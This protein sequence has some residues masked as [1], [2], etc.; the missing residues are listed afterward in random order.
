MGSLWF[1]GLLLGVCFYISLSETKSRPVEKFH[2]DYSR[3]QETDQTWKCW[4]EGY[5]PPPATSNKIQESAIRKISTFTLRLQSNEI[6]SSAYY[7]T[8]LD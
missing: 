5:R 6:D 7:W 8:M 4:K 3:I 1:Y 2:Y